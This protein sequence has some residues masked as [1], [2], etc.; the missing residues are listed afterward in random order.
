MIIGIN[1]Y[2]FGKI[3][4]ITT[5]KINTKLLPSIGFNQLKDVRSVAVIG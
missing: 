5:A 4:L 3:I 1:I 2:K